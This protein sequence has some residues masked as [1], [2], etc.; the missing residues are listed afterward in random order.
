MQAA[1]RSGELGERRLPPGRRA[2]ARVAG[3]ELGVRLVQLGG[4][5]QEVLDSDGQ[6]AA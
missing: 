2:M 3:G 5:R 6:A 1:V 4:Q